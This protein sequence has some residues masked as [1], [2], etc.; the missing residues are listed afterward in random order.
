MIVVM[1]NGATKE[2]C[3]LVELRLKDMGLRTHPIY[4]EEKTVIGAV[5][6]TK[7]QEL[8]SVLN[9]AGV[10]KIVPIARPY[11]LVG[12][13][14]KHDDTEI[15]IGGVNV[16][17][18]DLIVMAGP[19]AVEGEDQIYKAAEVV[20]N[21]GANVLR[22]GAFKPRTSPYA[23]QGLEEVGLRLLR[24][25]ASEV[26]LPVVTEV[27]DT[28]DVELV[29]RY[30]DILQVG[31]RNMHNYRLL[32]AVGMAGKPVL[33]KRGLAAT[34][35]EWLLAAEYVVDAGNPQVLLCE[36]GIRTYETMLR[37]TL[38]LAAVALVKQISHLPVIVDPSHG[39]GLSAL[40]TPMARA[41]IAAG[42]DGLMVEVHPNP[43]RALCDGQESLD[44]AE[45]ESLMDSISGVAEAVGKRLS[46]GRT[47]IS[48][49]G[50]SRTDV[51]THM[52]SVIMSAMG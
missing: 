23:F 15:L 8:D 16:G 38:D 40:V 6:D 31:A 17:G 20:K 51:P 1:R 27:L 13:E 18:D 4:G 32:K 33:L 43:S 10:E 36:R 39:T 3:E 37:N 14:L 29:S 41:A 35:E 50:V 30:A 44:Q 46:N 28:K 9:M 19:C 34:I 25:A 52:E 45:F 48:G 49:E 26:G 5:G 11:K 7:G 22:G 21:A 47:R 12:R 2:Q 42:A 24:A